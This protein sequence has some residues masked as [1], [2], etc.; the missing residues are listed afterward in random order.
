MSFEQL[1]K[2]PAFQGRKAAQRPPHT[3][4][5]YCEATVEE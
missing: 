3:V 4:S 5:N 2:G 1:W